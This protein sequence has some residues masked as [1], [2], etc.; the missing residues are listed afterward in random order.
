MPPPSLRALAATTFG[1][2]CI[3]H[4]SGPRSANAQVK[5][6]ASGRAGVW[7]PG[8]SRFPTPSLTADAHLALLPLVRVGAYG[9]LGY[10]PG[11]PDL[12]GAGGGTR[13][14]IALPLGWTQGKAWIYLGVGY[15]RYAI[16]EGGAAL[17]AVEIPTGFGLSRK[18]GHGLDLRTELGFRWAVAEFGDRNGQ[19][20]AFLPSTGTVELSLGIGYD[21]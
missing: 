21:P 14:K 13:A 20:P 7:L 9:M 19:E 15:A 12:L 2:V 10:R 11:T 6:E 3:L 16:G 8:P 1:I 18:V 5:W 4:M 17:H